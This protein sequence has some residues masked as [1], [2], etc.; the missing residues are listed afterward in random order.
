MHT[1]TKFYDPDKMARGNMVELLPK[2]KKRGWLTFYGGG[3]NSTPAAAMQCPHCSG[4]LAPSGKLLIKPEP[5]PV[6]TQAQKNQEAINE[7]FK[8][9][10]KTRAEL[11]QERIDAF[12][13]GD[14]SIRGTIPVEPFSEEDIRVVADITDYKEI[15]DRTCEICGKVCK[16]K[17]GLGSHMR[18]HKDKA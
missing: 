10:V 5:E 7:G 3:G 12:K 11:N 15:E 8:E 6:K 4:R 1:T 13:D 18:S 2:W 17:L 9:P 16:S 14:A